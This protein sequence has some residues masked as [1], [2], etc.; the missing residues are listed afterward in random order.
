MKLRLRSI[1]IRNWNSWHHQIH[2]CKSRACMWTY[3]HTNP[4]CPAKIRGTTA[5]Q[6][7]FCPKELSSQPQIYLFS[8]IVMFENCL[9]IE[10]ENHNT[11][12][13][14][15][16][17]NKKTPSYWFANKWYFG[18]RSFILQFIYIYIH[19][20]CEKGLLNGNWKKSLA[21]QRRST[22]LRNF[23]NLC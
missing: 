13:S 15:H 3:S 21:K 11:Q 9:S 7:P 10:Q 12:T 6:Y 16:I 14:S 18:A 8:S 5:S 2:G 20:Q 4:H 22:T 1:I 17:R 19:T 23:W